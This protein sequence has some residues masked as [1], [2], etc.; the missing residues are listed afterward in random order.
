M[1]GAAAAFLCGL[2]LPTQGFALCGSLVLVM[3]IGL[4]WPW[5]TLRAVSGSLSF[6]RQRVDEGDAVEATLTLHNRWPWAA[7]GLTVRGGFG[8]GGAMAG[9]AAI[10]GRRTA[11]YRWQFVPPGRGVYPIAPVLLSTG[12]PFGMWTASRRLEVE[13]RL[14]VWP[15]TFPVGP[16]PPVH[17]NQQVEGCVSRNSVGVSGDV[18]GVRPYRRGDSPRRIHWGQSAKYDRLIV[19]ELQSNDRPIV[20]VVLSN[21]GRGGR[22]DGE[23]AA[24]NENAKGNAGNGDASLAPCLREWTIR[25]AASLVRGWLEG[26]TRVGIMWDGGGLAPASGAAQLRNV[27]DALAALPETPGQT[28]A[29]ALPEAGRIGGNGLQV[30]VTTDL[31]PA[32]P[33]DGGEA[34]DRRWVILSSEGFGVSGSDGTRT[35]PTPWLWIDGPEFAPDRLRRGWREARHGS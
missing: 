23:G 2:I 16:V 20:M 8:A 9:F 3:G 31:V 28:L 7:R 34:A 19:C 11:V 32:P 14:I 25:I 21:E 26:G 13:G 35:H 30:I 10:P 4:V 5:L 12:F 33:Q 29:K 15:K 1:L 6:D 18:L 24:A 27:L 22:R 17:G